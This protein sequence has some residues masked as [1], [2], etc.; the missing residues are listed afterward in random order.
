MLISTDMMREDRFEPLL[1]TADA[2]KGRI[3]S[4]SPHHEAGRKLKNM[5]GVGAL[6]RFKI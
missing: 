2:K 6:L 1:K 4:I 3:V 5:G